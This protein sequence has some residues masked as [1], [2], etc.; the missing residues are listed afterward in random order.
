[1]TRFIAFHDDSNGGND[2]KIGARGR[3]TALVTPIILR[4]P[5]NRQI[6]T[7]GNIYVSPP[8]LNIIHEDCFVFIRIC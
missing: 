3:W 2:T 7:S 1:M 4:V 8:T 5:K 6:L